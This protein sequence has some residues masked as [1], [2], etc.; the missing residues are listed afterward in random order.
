MRPLADAD[1]Q[2]RAHTGCVR[3][4][5]HGRAVVRVSRTVKMRMRIDQQKCLML[6]CMESFFLCATSVLFQKFIS[7]QQLSS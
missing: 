3:A 6:R 1:G 4:L 2:R 7:K 5:E